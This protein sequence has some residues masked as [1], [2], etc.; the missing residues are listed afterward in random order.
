MALTTD[1]FIAEFIKNYDNQAFDEQVT[2]VKENQALIPSAVD[3]LINSANQPNLTFEEKMWFLNIAS[4]LAYMNMH[5]HNDDQPLKT[6]EPIIKEELQKEQTRLAILMKWKKEERFIGNFVMK[7][8]QAQMEKQGL[9]MVMYPHWLHRVMFE[10]KV[11]HN[12]IFK[13]RRWENDISHQ[14]IEEG[15]QCGACHN[16]EMAFSATDENS[17]DR[18]HIVGKPEAE[19]LHNP[20]LVKQESIKKAAQS[21][22]AKWRPENLTDNRLPVDRFQFIDWLELKNKSVFAPVISLD[23]NFKDEIRDNQIVFQSKS[24]FVGDV[25][26]D[27]KVHSEWIRCD[28][29][30]PAL[31]KEELGGNKIKM[32]EISKGRFC[33]HCHGKVSFTFADC[34]RCHKKSIGKLSADESRKENVLRRVE[35]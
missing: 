32:T 27:H 21:V 35:H 10:C 1:A 2:L 9:S 6:V 18:C 26:F 19:H 13:M 31:F 33:G 28:S 14:N 22:G 3:N 8:N 24:D 25:I 16:G 12:S 15:K 29:C 17:C 34:L 20:N 5:W 11:C 7:K 30:H 23:E 4:S